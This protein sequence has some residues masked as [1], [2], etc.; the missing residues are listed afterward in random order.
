M[1]QDTITVDVSEWSQSFRGEADFEWIWR[2]IYGHGASIE[3]GR[4]LFRGI[5]TVAIDRNGGSRGGG[6]VRVLPMEDAG[7]E[8]EAIARSPVVAAVTLQA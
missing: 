8:G 2:S 7:I 1:Y 6:D 3:L 4:G 5:R